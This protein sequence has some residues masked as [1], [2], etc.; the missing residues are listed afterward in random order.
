MCRGLYFGA[1]LEKLILAYKLALQVTFPS[2]PQRLFEG[3]NWGLFWGMFIGLLVHWT[4][5]MQGPEIETKI[6]PNQ[7][8]WKSASSAMFIGIIVTLVLGVVLGLLFGLAYLN[9]QKLYDYRFFWVFAALSY[10]AL[11]G[12]ING[13]GQACIRHFTLR[14]LLWRK[15]NIPWNYVRFLDY[16]TDR[17]F[18][19]KVGGG[20]IFIHRMLMEHFAQMS[21]QEVT[22]LTTEEG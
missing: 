8:I 14:F 17:I 3:L 7:G 20:Y 18:L 10:G 15:G 12:L 1:T 21:G 2:L 22:Q 11:I 19:Q 4:E 13:G 5:G 9:N 6:K 16:A